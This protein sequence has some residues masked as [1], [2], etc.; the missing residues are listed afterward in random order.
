MKMKNKLTTEEYA[1]ILRSE[2]YGFIERSFYELNPS[3]TFRKNWH[4]EVIAYELERL[5][6]GQN[7]RL[8][9]NVPPRSLKSHCASICFPAWLLGH[10]PSAQ[11]I[12][13]SYA[14]DLS[15]KLASDCR[16]LMTSSMYKNIFSTR[17]SSVR[18]AIQELATR[19]GGFRLATSVGGVLTGRGGDYLIVDDPLKPEGAAS[20]VERTRVNEW[21]DH[22]LLSR[23]NEQNEGRIVIIMQRLHQDDLVGHISEKTGWPVLCLPAIAST[24][25]TFRIV[26]SLGRA[27][28]YARKVGEVLHPDRQDL[29]TL[30][31]IKDSI[32]SYNFSGQ[33]QQSPSPEGGGMI[34]KEWFQTY[35]PES[36][37][38]PFDHIF[39][40]WDTASKVTELSDFSVCTTWGRKGKYL[41]LLHVYRK[42][43][44]YP[45]LKRAVFAQAQDWGAT[46][47]VIEDT[48]SGTQLI[49]ELKLECRYN[50]QSYRPRPGEDKVMRMFECCNP[51]ENGFIYLP[52]KAAWLQVYID[53]LTVFPRG[54]HDDQVD[55]TS[56][57]LDWIKRIHLESTMNTVTVTT[58]RI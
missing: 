37:P 45:T 8:I 24:D 4:L 33:F 6:L 40:S 49:Q 52:E 36:C 35:T 54:K 18:P 44:D 11:I 22:T 47:I 51:I 48:S 29:A 10:E 30:E 55:S 56:Q 9:I 17:L 23:L 3:T 15:D 46:T 39:Q 20:E 57:A 28:T 32:G 14:Q 53:E 38:E 50:I 16:S 58:V 34:R 27:R 31:R 41:Y 13:A 12:C 19:Q 1:A 21:F 43:M 26:T 7:T 25:E 42:K 2:F 5:R